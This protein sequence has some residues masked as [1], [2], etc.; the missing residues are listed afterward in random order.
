MSS[1]A[2]TNLLASLTTPTASDTTQAPSTSPVLA[3]TRA[4][5]PLPPL[6]AACPQV[7][8]TIVPRSALTHTTVAAASLVLISLL[9][10]PTLRAAWATTLRTTPLCGVR[11]TAC[12]LAPLLHILPAPGLLRWT[13]V[14][15]NAQMLTTPAAASLVLTSLPVLQTTATALASLPSDPTVLS[16]LRLALLPASLPLVLPRLP[17]EV[18]NCLLP[19]LPCTLWVFWLF[20]KENEIVNNGYGGMGLRDLL[21]MENVQV[22]A[23][24]N[25]SGWDG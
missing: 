15:R 2:Q 8:L 21:N 6:R 22:V 24:G 9:A 25:H 11:R 10:A 20:C 23:G 16:L 7:C 18:L 3:S 17:L 19:M 1:L 5:Q 13:T 12:P 14:P 4:A